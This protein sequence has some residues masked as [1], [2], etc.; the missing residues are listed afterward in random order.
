MS[1]SGTNLVLRW[2]ASATNFVLEAASECSAAGWAT[3][4]N[5]PVQV[6]QDIVVTNHPQLQ[7][8]FYRLRK[9]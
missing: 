1:S 5:T 8:Q 4:T 9:R 7:T 2:P 3:L 6:G